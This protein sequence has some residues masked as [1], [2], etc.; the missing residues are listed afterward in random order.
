MS[1]PTKLVSRLQFRR[2][3]TAVYLV[4]EIDSARVVAAEWCDVL[5]PVHLQL[6]ESRR[7]NSDAPVTLLIKAHEVRACVRARVF[8]F[9]LMF[10]CECAFVRVFVCVCE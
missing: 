9:A 8:V 2:P 5:E 3:V 1:V 4:E 7:P 10:V 6:V